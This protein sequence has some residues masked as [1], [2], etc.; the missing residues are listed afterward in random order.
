[1]RLKIITRSILLLIAI[2]LGA[3]VY[4]TNSDVGKEK[5][6]AEQVIDGLLDGDEL[7]LDDGSGHEF[8]GILTEGDT[9]SG[10]AVILVHGIGVHPNWPDV[11]FPL[12]EAML[13][14]EITSLSIQM[15]ILP[16]E[17]EDSEYS[18]LYPEVPGRL[19][20]AVDFLKDSGYARV[21][22]VGHSLGARMATYYLAQQ[23]TDGVNS[24]VLIGMGNSSSGSWPESIDALARLRVPVLDLYGG[25]DLDTVLNTVQDRATSGQKNKSGIYRQIRVED[26]NHFF[27]GHENALKQHVIDWLNK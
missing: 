1:M 26:A 6:W 21:D 9:E 18:A 16:N 27:Q 23:G 14:N 25:K 17:A 10:R 12:R 15:P 3:P 7:W 22:I 11:I 2:A 5:R 8:L 19:Q 4:A 24:V 13:E 20:A